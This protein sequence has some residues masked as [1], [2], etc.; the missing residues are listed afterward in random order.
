MLLKIGVTDLRRKLKEHLATIGN[1]S[2]IIYS[3]GTDAEVLL[4]SPNTLAKLE[5]RH[6]INTW[7]RNQFHGLHLDS[8]MTLIEGKRTKD[9]PLDT[10]IGLSA[11]FQLVQE[12]ADVLSR[13]TAKENASKWDVTEYINQAAHEQAF[14]SHGKFDTIYTIITKL[15]YPAQ[16]DITYLE[17]EERTLNGFLNKLV[18]MAVED[19]ETLQKGTTNNLTLKAFELDAEQITIVLNTVIRTSAWAS[20]LIDTQTLNPF[21][22]DKPDM[23]FLQFHELVKWYE[24]T[25]G[26]LPKNPGYDITIEAWGKSMG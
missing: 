7:A 8:Y 22:D 24:E 3:T 25:I 10:L 23:L 18:C 12:I 9:L 17:K 13:P 6:Y 20:E 2:D 4:M 14:T 21:S 1:T 19:K 26:E 16:F 11:L 5:R 15:Y